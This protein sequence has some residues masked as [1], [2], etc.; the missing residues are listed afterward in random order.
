MFLI[1]VTLNKSK[2]KFNMIILEKKKKKTLI[3]PR[4]EK[5]FIKMDFDS[6]LSVLEPWSPVIDLVSFGAPQFGK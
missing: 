5:L 6:A 1:F 2:P 4:R 3:L